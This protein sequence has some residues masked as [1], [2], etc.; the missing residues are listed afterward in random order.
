[1][2][3]RIVR[4]VTMTIDELKLIENWYDTCMK[5]NCT[6]NEE[7]KQLAKEINELIEKNGG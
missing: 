1:M 3:G 7:E 4:E 5:L 6:C 2:S